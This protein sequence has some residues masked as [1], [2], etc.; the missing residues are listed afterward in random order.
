MRV[1]VLG[2]NSDMARALCEKFAGR[3]AE[4]MYL[5]S[6]DTA[7]LEKLA[8]D[9]AIR[10]QVNAV[11]LAFDVA[12]Y[13]SHH[14]FY[15]SLQP[16][17]D[18]VVAA[19]GYTGDQERAQADFAEA[20]KMIETNYAGAVS[21]LEIAA[22]Q[23][24]NAGKGVIIGIASVAGLRGRA[25]N[26]IYGSAKAG[27]IAYLSGLRNRL[28]PKGV[29]VITVLPGFIRTKMTEGMELP[30]AL[31]GEPEDAAREI[32]RALDSGADI[33]YTRWYWRYIMWVIRAIPERLFKRTR[34]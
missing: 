14:A 10:Y 29:R 25:S 15:E 34:I 26:Y 30:P 22:A 20:R 24:E 4:T 27:F 5:A 17:P 2:A 3:M 16:A 1:L 32:M 33:V 8:R 11:P 9:L 23:M 19:F 18:V 31:V 6:R 13:G 12:D 21:I 7:L 28:S